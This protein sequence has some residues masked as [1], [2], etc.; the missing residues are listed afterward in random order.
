MSPI[1]MPSWAP[2]WTR[3]S[4]AS[5]PA[6]FDVPNEPPMPRLIIFDEQ[7][8]NS[9]EKH[10]DLKRLRRLF[11]WRRVSLGKGLGYPL[12][13]VLR[14]TWR[15]CDPL[16]CVLRVTGRR[17]ATVWTTWRGSS[18]ST[19]APSNTYR[20]LKNNG[21][22]WHNPSQN[23]GTKGCTKRLKFWT[24]IQSHSNAMLS[25]GAFEG[26]IPPS[27]GGLC[28]KCYKMDR[29]LGCI[30]EK[31]GCKVLCF[32]KS[33]SWHYDKYELEEFLEKMIKYGTG[34][35]IF[36]TDHSLGFGTFGG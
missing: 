35:R 34:R 2:D 3:R 17:C 31:G 20:H 29:E 36:A 10:V 6:Q 18:A 15:R 23:S 21:H 13:R 30:G 33:G 32:C 28:Q 4:P 1:K 5:L 27:F 19:I 16:E 9:G 24:Q 25:Y 26:D 14:V 12:E 11:F 7:S 8:L 22:W